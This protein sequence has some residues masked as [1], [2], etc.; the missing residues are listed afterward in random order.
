MYIYYGTQ[1]YGKVDHA[2]GL[3]YVATTFFHLYFFPL[4]PGDSYLIMDD[5]TGEN[6]VPMRTSLWSVVVGWGRAVGLVAGALMVLIPAFNPGM[7]SGPRW[8][9]MAGGVVS[10]V[11]T[12]LT[13]RW[14][15]IGR[16]RA[17]R[18]AERAGLDPSFVHDHFDRLEGKPPAERPRNDRLNGLQ[19]D[20]AM[21]RWNPNQTSEN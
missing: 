15:C 6:G 11:L 5:G 7:D 4:V 20:E 10:L 9:Y 16:D 2:P 21:R 12:L 8:G 13:Y 1:L 3:F 14:V 19:L 18:L 17:E